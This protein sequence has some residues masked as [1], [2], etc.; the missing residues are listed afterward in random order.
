[1]QL[2]QD[3]PDFD[4]VLRAADGRTALV[5]AERLE[6][7]FLVAPDRLVR[8]WPVASLA[9][10]AAADLEP[11]LA[12]SPEV[13]VLGTGARQG[14]PPPDV[15]AACLTRGVGLE[16]MANDAA[17]RTFNILA[18]EGRR[19]VAAFILEG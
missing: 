3:R 13:L 4:Y 10:L 14:F 12:L 8:D 7:S 5:N 16:P 18:G 15:M 17:A 19:V 9:A 6:A 1:M 11:A 2:S